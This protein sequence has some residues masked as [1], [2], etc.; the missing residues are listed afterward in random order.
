MYVAGNCFTALTAHAHISTMIARAENMPRNPTRVLTALL[1]V[2]ALSAATLRYAERFPAQNASLAPRG[3][4]NF[5]QVSQQLYRG[6]QPTPQGF[7]ELK[8]LGVEI[9]VNLRDEPDQ[10]AAER[11]TVEPLGLRYVSIPWN[12]WHQPSSQQV[13]E[14]LALLQANPRK[15]IFVHC[16]HG[17]DRTGVMVAAYR[18][19]DEH[20]TPAQAIQEMDAFH[21]HGFWLRHLK[22]YVQDF[23]RQLAA[24]P[25]LR[26]LRPAAETSSP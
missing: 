19:A 7:A 14:F 26:A 2:V 13:A 22:R 18:I 21:F 24:D 10:I 15:K 17:A 9:V 6:A 1:A 12:S 16:H 23:P 11:Q 25:S 5:G 8:K 20:W 3:V 4:A